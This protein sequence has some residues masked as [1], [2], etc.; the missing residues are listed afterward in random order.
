MAFAADQTKPT[1]QQSAR[2][3]SIIRFVWHHQAGTDDDGVIRAIQSGARELSCTWTVNSSGRVTALVPEDRRPWTS[4]SQFVDGRALTVEVEN[5]SGNPDWGISDAAHEAC[6]RLAAYAFV[7]YGVPLRRIRSAADQGAGHIG[8]GEL[9]A[10]FGEGYA[11][12]CP[13]HLDIDRILARAQQLVG[14]PNTSLG[15]GLSE[16]DDM[17]DSERAK[18]DEI[19]AAVQGLRQTWIDTNG[20]AEQAVRNTG[21]LADLRQTIIDGNQRAALLVASLIGKPTAAVDTA[22]IAAAV[23]DALDDDLAKSVAD[24]LAKRLA[25]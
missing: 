18:L 13:G 21:P 4:D 8:H 14:D 11:T 16:E 6:A 25:A 3:G 23:A 22:A 2:T 17:N 24:L 10:V 15:G 7:A 19:H 12:F 5:S 9:P 20:R 1:S